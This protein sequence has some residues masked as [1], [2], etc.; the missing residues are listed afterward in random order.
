M[1]ATA[2]PVSRRLIGL[3]RMSWRGYSYKT[4]KWL[5][6]DLV[7]EDEDVDEVEEDAED[8]DSD[9]EVSVYWLVSI[10]VN[11]LPID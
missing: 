1:S 10:L 6:A 5:L 8:T 11:I 2:I 4:D 9:G 3:A 7:C